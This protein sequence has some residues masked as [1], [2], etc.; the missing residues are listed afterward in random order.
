MNKMKMWQGSLGVSEFEGIVSPAYI[1]CK[2]STE[3]NLKY[4]HML[5]RSSKF[6]T[7]YNR[8]SYGIRVGQWDMRYDDFKKLYILL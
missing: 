6:K 7:F 5:L 1:V 4:L 2:L 3:A 8:S